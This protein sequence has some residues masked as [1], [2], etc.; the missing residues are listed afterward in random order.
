MLV[1]LLDVRLLASVNDG[2]QAMAC[3][4]TVSEART[5][6]CVTVAA[7]DDLPSPSHLLLNKQNANVQSVVKQ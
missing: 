6:S 3:N 2:E 5:S 1:A 7:I 4:F